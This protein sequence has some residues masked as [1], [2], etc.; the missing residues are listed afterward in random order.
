MLPIIDTGD[1]EACLQ[2]IADRRSTV[3]PGIETAVRTI[4]AE[5]AKRGDHAVR[6]FTERFDRVSIGPISV[7]QEALQAAFEQSDAEWRR[8]ITEAADNIRRFHEKQLRE[9]WFTDDGDGVRLGQRM[10]PMERVALYIPGGTAAYPSSVLMTA[11]PA[12]VAGVAEIHLVSPPQSGGIPHPLVLATAHMLDLQRVYAVGGA[13]AIAALAYGTQSIPRVDKIVGPGNAYVTMAKKLVYGQV[14]IDSLAGPSEVIV[15][16]DE[17]ASPVFIAHDLLAQAE[18]DVRASAILVTPHRE[19]A[20]AV[21]AQLA[22]I[23]PTLER[24]A[25]AEQA[26]AECGACIVTTSME[27]AIRVVNYLAPE[28]LELLVREPWAM[29][30]HIRHAG[31]VFL[32]P[33]SPEPVGDYYAGPNHVL[34]TGGTARYASAL[35]VDDFLRQQSVISYSRERLVTTGPSIVAL[36]HSEGLSAHA[37]AV[38]VRLRS[39]ASFV[40]SRQDGS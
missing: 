18:H 5:V 32:G 15:L 36:A 11:I 39:E 23:T 9:S 33:Y 13:Q 12:Q 25:I 14:D 27:E 24:Q 20:D 10:L 3:D 31:A 22:Q 6:A 35:G 7:P 16:A 37:E 19:T 38:A 34:P 40:N 1:W 8:V 28:H 29:L 17:T 26:L 21:L 4:I 30:E 2:A